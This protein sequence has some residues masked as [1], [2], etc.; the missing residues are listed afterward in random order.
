VDAVEGG[1]IEFAAFVVVVPGQT[2]VDPVVF[3]VRATGQADDVRSGIVVVDLG[4]TSAYL[5][6]VAQDHDLLVMLGNNDGQ[7]P[8]RRRVR[9][10]A[11]LRGIEVL[12]GYFLS[13][14]IHGSQQAGL[15]SGDVIKGIAFHHN[16]GAECGDTEKLLRKGV[17]KMNASVALG[18]AGQAAGVESHP[19]P[20]KALL[21]GHGR[22]VVL[23]GMVAGVLL[24]D[25]E[26][27]GWGF[28][29]G[30][31]R[32]DGAD[33]DAHSVAVDSG[34]LAREIDIDKDWTGGRD[35][36]GPDPLAGLQSVGDA[37]ELGR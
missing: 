17:R 1:F 10:P 13:H 3:A 6:A 9:L 21:E 19:I 36:C 30:L 7:R 33:C 32:R 28:M 20:G 4:H 15:C 37:G 8:G 2:D 25:G 5:D 18:I 27:P 31:T 35:V 12:L 26:D 16:G 23:L 11:K 22:V 29:S 34:A 14:D 24:Q